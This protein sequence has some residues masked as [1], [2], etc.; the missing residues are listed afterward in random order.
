[1][2]SE[3]LSINSN[4]I[5]KWMYTKAYIYLIQRSCTIHYTQCTQA[6]DLTAAIGTGAYPGGVLR[7]LEHPP[8]PSIYRKDLLRDLSLYQQLLLQI[9]ICRQ[10]C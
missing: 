4:Y 6:Q 2:H 3:R 1:M 10:K 9:I 7:V 5:K 8:Q